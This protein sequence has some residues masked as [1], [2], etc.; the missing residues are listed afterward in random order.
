MA[1]K[2]TNVSPKRKEWSFDTRTQ[3]ADLE[4]HFANW[5]NIKLRNTSG[6][7]GAHLW[8]KNIGT[9]PLKDI[10][11]QID[12]DDN[13]LNYDANLR[14][15][16]GNPTNVRSIEFGDLQ[17]NQESYKQTITWEGSSPFED[18]I[19]NGDVAEIRFI[20]RPKYTIDYRSQPANFVAET[21]L[22]ETKVS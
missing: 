20:L 13:S 5:P 17:P 6:W 22:T 10:L 18:E 16:N 21:T 9:L 7:L 4:I 1:L 3:S 14:D 2:F 11:V 8:V 19:A 12:V 15:E